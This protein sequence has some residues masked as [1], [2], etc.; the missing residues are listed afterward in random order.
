MAPEQLDG[1]RRGVDARADVYALGAILFEILTH[2]PL[3]ARE[4]VARVIGSTIAGVDIEDRAA[5]GEVDIPPELVTLCAR[6]TAVDPE[7]RFPSVG[8]LLEPL[9]R[10]LDG[11]RNLA[12]RRRLARAAFD[13][14]TAATRDAI[15]LGDAA[16]RRRALAACSRVLALDPDHE[17]TRAELVRLLV[18][19][20]RETPPEVDTELRE[21]ERE[22]ARLDV[23]GGIPAFASFLAFVPVLAW[24]GLRDPAMLGAMIGLLAV[25][26]LV[27][28]VGS[29]MRRPETWPMAVM[30]LISTMALMILSRLLG[31]FVLVPGL[32]MAN[33]IALSLQTRG[34]R[35]IALV[36][37]ASMAMVVPA[38]L[39]L[40]G[41]LP[42]SYTF[43][44]D[45]MVVRPHLTDLPRYQTLVLLW[46][47][48][49]A[50]IV[51]PAALVSR[52]RDAL[53]DAERRLAVVAWQLRQLVPSQSGARPV[54]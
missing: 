29:R 51:L 28:G 49:L 32:A 1:P 14:V 37:L 43:I 20:P 35:R 36:T 4:T 5:Q 10:F 44:D 26:A 52:P 40:I 41:I 50:A 47:G 48:N 30:V 39:E 45:T 25:G 42:A 22:T 13:E 11:D 18:T 33:A 46:V 6:A 54:A 31:P 53:R 27:S 23:R 16:A 7:E 8:D 21:R 17:A 19:P 15:E 2:V 34:R 3:H 24:M 9:E 12:L 38:A